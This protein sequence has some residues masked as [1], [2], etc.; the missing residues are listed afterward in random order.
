MNREESI[1][2]DTME[3]CAELSKCVSKLLRFGDET[4]LAESNPTDL[5]NCFHKLEAMI[6]LLQDRGVVPVLPEE[7]AELVRK[8]KIKMFNHFIG[9]S[10]ENGRISD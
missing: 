2:I 7:E 1:L 8:N 10:Y 6:Q 3:C 4:A 5:V 9:V